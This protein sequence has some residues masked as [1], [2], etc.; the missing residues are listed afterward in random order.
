MADDN[1]EELEEAEQ[2]PFNYEYLRRMLA[3][4][5]PY[6]REMVIVIVAMIVGSVL[7]LMEPYLL[8]TAIDEG[9]VAG[10]LGVVNRMAAFWL[11]FQLAGAA[12]DYVRIHILN[13]TGQHIL[14]DMRQ[15]LFDHL[16]WLSLRFYD[17]RPVGRIMARVTNDVEA[18]NNLI[19][20]GLV[21]IVSQSV[22]IVGI[23]AVMF[24]LNWRL[25]LLAF[26][27]IP[28]ML[29]VVTRLRPAMEASW[30]NVRRANSNINAYL[31][32]SVSGI[33]VTQAFNREPENIRAFDQLNRAYYDAFMR[34]IKIEI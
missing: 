17:G 23:V 25:A 28:G 34:A 31:N 32:E 15:Q 4:T 26:A 3:Y 1:Y 21:T 10:N 6:R 9:I 11:L 24:W 22:S 7:R 29:W 16:Q 13:Y 18:I 33:R 20:G 14:F 19:N 30:R 5:R 27:V 8:R 12:G 2:K